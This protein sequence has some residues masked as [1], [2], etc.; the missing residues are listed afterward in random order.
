MVP[1]AQGSGRLPRMDRVRHS[2]RSNLSQNHER[3]CTPCAERCPVCHCRY[4]GQNTSSSPAS[5]VIA[6]PAFRL[7]PPLPLPITC[8]YTPV[9]GGCYR[10]VSIVLNLPTRSDG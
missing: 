1:T 6:P 10:P 4:G 8:N 5:F 9:R 7:Q 3:P 2:R